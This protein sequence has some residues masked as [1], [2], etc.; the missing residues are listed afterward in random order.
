M[1]K[2]KT[3]RGVLY[4]SLSIIFYIIGSN[5]IDT[6]G[7]SFELSM[8]IIYNILGWKGMIL[9]VLLSIFTTSNLI[10]AIYNFRLGINIFFDKKIKES[11]KY[12]IYRTIINLL[13]ILF[14][15]Y[16]IAFRT[17]FVNLNQIY[18][19]S[20]IHIIISIFSVII[21][22]SLFSIEFA[23]LFTEKKRNSTKNVKESNI[24]RVETTPVQLNKE[25]EPP[26]FKFGTKTKRRK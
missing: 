21:S 3:L 19:E 20:V 15:I 14:I 25:L 5:Y 18:L 8:R 4:L 24:V 1:L 12:H 6:L 2:N 11:R 23:L 13:N 22:C 7:I 10:S 17:D 16:L 9:A 26:I